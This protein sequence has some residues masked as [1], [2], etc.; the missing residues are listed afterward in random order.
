MS[1]ERWTLSEL[2]I[3]PAAYLPVFIIWVGCMIAV[4]LLARHGDRGKTRG[5]MFGVVAQATLAAVYLIYAWSPVHALWAIVVVPLLGWIA[6]FVGSRTGIPF[7]HYHYTE[8]LQP[9]IHRVPVAIPL[10]WLMMLPPSWAV[11]EL[12]A[13]S[14][15]WWVRATI[16]ATAF[17]AWDVYLDPQ[18]VTWAFWKWDVP[19]RYYVGIPLGNFL[20]WF[21]WAWIISAVVQPASL[22]GTPFILVYLLTWLFQFGGHLVFWKMPLSGLVGFIAM[23]VPSAAAV[24]SLLRLLS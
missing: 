8:A 10:A 13:P 20:G 24:W 15:P 3:G 22:L 9:Q 17:T 4:P 2:V 19:G 16:A 23:G 7:G 21:I 11:A 1:P 12:I 14:G 5:I 6:E 18:L